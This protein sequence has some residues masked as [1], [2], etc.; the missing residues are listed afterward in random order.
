MAEEGHLPPG[1]VRRI[2]ATTSMEHQA[3][4]EVLP[5]KKKKWRTTPPFIYSSPKKF[6]GILLSFI[7]YF[8]FYY[9]AGLFFFLRTTFFYVCMAIRGVYS[10]MAEVSIYKFIVHKKWTTLSP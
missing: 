7:I 8:S 2:E 10:K 4:K 3:L 5:I 9:R 1:D 6:F